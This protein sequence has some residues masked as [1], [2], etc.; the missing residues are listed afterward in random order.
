[1]SPH[2]P[3]ELAFDCRVIR[4]AI[5]SRLLVP[6]LLR[7]LSWDLSQRLSWDLSRDCSRNRSKGLSSDFSSDS[8]PPNSDPD[9]K[10]RNPARRALPAAQSRRRWWLQIE[11]EPTPLMKPQKTNALTSPGCAAPQ[12]R[13]GVVGPRFCG[14]R[15]SGSYTATRNSLAFSLVPSP[16]S[17]GLAS[18]QAS[19]PI[20]CGSDRYRTSM[21]LGLDRPDYRVAPNRF[22]HPPWARTRGTVPRVAMAC[23][24]FF[25]HPGFFHPGGVSPIPRRRRVGTGPHGVW[26]R[27]P[28]P[29]A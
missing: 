2:N 3:W 16:E 15:P 27:H 17:I 18:T 12:G 29:K 25:W 11:I 7:G 22:Q 26:I 28:D 1:M 14:S 13:F 21:S 19:R 20:R 10:P 23:Q 6:E 5:T 24:I 8:P 4:P 9:R